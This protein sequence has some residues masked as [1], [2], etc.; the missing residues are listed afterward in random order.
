MAQGDGLQLQSGAAAETAAEQR[1]EHR[2]DGEHALML[3]HQL[4]NSRLSLA[5]RVLSRDNV[6]SRRE[7]LSY[8]ASSLKYPKGDRLGMKVVGARCLDL[9]QLGALAKRWKHQQDHGGADQ[10]RADQESSDGP[11]FP[12]L[13]CEHQCGERDRDERRI[14]NH[15]ELKE[16]HR[17]AARPTAGSSAFP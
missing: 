14:P 7:L 8:V 17:L 4:A 1:P 2:K 11:V 10:S 12:A 3:L 9:P 6:S 5:H 16:A 13:A 15:Q